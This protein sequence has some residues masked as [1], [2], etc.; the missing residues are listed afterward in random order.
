MQTWNHLI[1][2]GRHLTE[3]ARD[4]PEPA[5]DSSEPAEPAK[6]VL[7]DNTNHYH[8]YPLAQLEQ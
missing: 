1:K 4:L 8:H 7:S 6:P 3:P 5:Y 2:P